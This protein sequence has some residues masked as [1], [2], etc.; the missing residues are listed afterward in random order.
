MSSISVVI[1]TPKDTSTMVKPASDKVSLKRVSNLLDGL[2]SGSL[3]G[4]VKLTASTVDAVAASGTYTLDTVIAT[5]T[6]TIGAVTLTGT[7]TPSTELHFDT[8][9]GSDTLIAVSLAGA[10]NAHSTLK[11]Q[12]YATSSGDVVTVTCRVPGVIGNLVEF[13]DGDTTITS[14]GSGYLAGGTG[15]SGDLATPLTI[16]R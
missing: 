6:V 8:D 10:I 15:G 2:S 13:T 14:S 1:T 7:D 3:R 4:D 12:V 16:G 9:A 11:H 5:D